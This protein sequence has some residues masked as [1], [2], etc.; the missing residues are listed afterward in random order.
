MEPARLYESPFTDHAPT[1]PDLLF[2]DP[3]VDG[4]VVILDDIRQHAVA[5]ADSF[6]TDAWTATS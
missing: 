6:G 3:E 4:I 5:R 1:G 2:S